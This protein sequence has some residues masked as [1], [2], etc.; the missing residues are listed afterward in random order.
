[1]TLLPIQLVPIVLSRT[2]GTST[3][4]TSSTYVFELLNSVTLFSEQ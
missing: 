4:D 3:Y 2:P 1:M